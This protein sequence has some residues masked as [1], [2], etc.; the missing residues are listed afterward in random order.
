MGRK[1]SAAVTCSSGPAEM[2][3]GN[4]GITTGSTS[5][6]RVLSP[7]HFG[8]EF[9][10]NGHSDLAAGFRYVL[11]VGPGVIHRIQ[12]LLGKQDFQQSFLEVASS[13]VIKPRVE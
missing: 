9:G 2:R 6:G 4:S 11:D 13:D 1:G 10:G 12:F 3:S 8:A 5:A 7:A